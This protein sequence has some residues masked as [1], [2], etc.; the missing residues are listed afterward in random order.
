MAHK[1]YPNIFSEFKIGNIVIPNRLVM[2]PMGVGHYGA[3]FEERLVEFY[4]ARARGG[5]GLILTENCYVDSFEADPYPRFMPVPRFDD[6]TKI[7]RAHAI[8]QRVKYYGGVPGIQ[9]GAGQGRNAEGLI[10]EQP[11]ASSSVMPCLDDP[12]I[13]CREMT[14][15]DIQRKLDAF[16]RAAGMAVECG[17][18]IIEVH[19]HS[20]YLLEQFFNKNINR[21]TDKYG[22]NAENRFRFAAEILQAIRKGSGGKVGVSIRLS[23]DHVCSDGITL[24]EGLEYCKLAE[25]AGYD[26]VHVDAG[27]R[28]ALEW[29]VPPPYLGTTPLRK[30]AKAAKQVVNIP[31]IAVGGYL[32]PE[33]VEDTLASG[34]ADFV[35]LGRA[36][37][38]DPDWAMK[39]KL[40]KEDE[41]RGCIQCAERCSMYTFFNKAATCSVN[42]TCGVENDLKLEKTENPKRVTVIGGGPAG[43]VTALVA[44]RRGHQVKLLEKSDKLGGNMNIVGMEECKPGVRNYN[45]YLQRQMEIHN[46]D[47]EYNC[48]ATLEKVRETNPDAVVAAT[49]SE[50]FIPGI[51]GFDSEKVVDVKEYHERVKPTL[52]GGEKM[53]VV[54]GGITGTEVALALGEK[55][56]DVTLVEYMSDFATDLCYVNRSGLMHQ[57]ERHSDNI[58]LMPNTKCVRIE[59]DTLYCEGKDGSEIK[60]PFEHVVCCIGLRAD[61]TLAKQL[62]DEYPETYIIGDVKERKKIGDAVQAAFF[63]GTRL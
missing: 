32:M 43:M 33:E 7:S 42:P 11:P 44:K 9:L 60:L 28:A 14:E 59:G 37:M 26:A 5:L 27:S 57:I 3:F 23:L 38:A 55:G 16:E 1:K 47:V 31:V 29:T 61:D 45:R 18:E 51:P 49:G 4:G 15:A 19:A 46:I 34:D 48:E 10:P 25:K 52:K 36:I 53:V 50:I 54:G 17:F 20:G 8:A 24:E 56:C 13:M 2:S 58:T 30:Y 41:I 62:A 63:T 22:G 40:G 12:S 6:K 39:V 35:A 21:R